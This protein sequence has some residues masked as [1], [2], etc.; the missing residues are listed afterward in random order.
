MS[1][2]GGQIPRIWSIW[3]SSWRTALRLLPQTLPVLLLTQLAS[4]LGLLMNR[5]GTLAQTTYASPALVVCAAV[6][7]LASTSV[8]T[9]RA[10]ALFRH[11][12]RAGRAA[13]LTSVGEHSVSEH[14]S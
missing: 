10:L 2:R 7:G 6:G 12:R 14:S 4:L 13:G 9:A 1:F 3:R 5:S 11:R 8:I